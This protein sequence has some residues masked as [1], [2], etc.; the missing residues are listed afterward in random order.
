MISNE[1]IF[2]FGIKKKKNQKKILNLIQYKKN[3]KILIKN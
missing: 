3:F 1:Q 2:F